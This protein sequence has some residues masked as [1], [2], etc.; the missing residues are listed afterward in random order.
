ME[1]KVDRFCE[2][3]DAEDLTT[4]HG[5]SLAPWMLGNGVSSPNHRSRSTELQLRALAA[6][7]PEKFRE[8]YSHSGPKTSGPN[9]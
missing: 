8:R 2:K 1:E 7:E 3:K 9:L 4:L 5:L 6:I